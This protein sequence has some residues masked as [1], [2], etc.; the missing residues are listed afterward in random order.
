MIRNALS[1]ITNS[2]RGGGGFGKQQ[3]QQAKEGPYK[4]QQHPTAR[5]AKNFFSSHSQR[6]DAAEGLPPPAPPVPGRSPKRDE[7]PT[8]VDVPSQVCDEAWLGSIFPNSATSSARSSFISSPRGT[9]DTV[10]DQ[11]EGEEEQGEK[12]H[13]D[14][15]KIEVLPDILASASSAQPGGR[16]AAPEG[17]EGYQDGTQL[18]GDKLGASRSISPSVVFASQ[19]HLAGHHSCL[20]ASLTAISPAVPEHSWW[21]CDY[22]G[23]AFTTF[24]DASCHE[25]GC[26]LNLDHAAA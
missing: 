15:G 9:A 21:E 24:D 12:E 19:A 3:Q 16:H 14:R 2:G 7:G 11:S 6:D 26:T 25:A 23:L 13:L 8:L 17:Y 1:N 10:S 22:C 20:H 5:R 4:Q 18:Q